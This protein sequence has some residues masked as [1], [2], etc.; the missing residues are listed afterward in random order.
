VFF[1]Y[2]RAFRAITLAMLRLVRRGEAV[3]LLDRGEAFLLQAPD[4]QHSREFQVSPRDNNLSSE[5]HHHVS[6]F[7]CEPQ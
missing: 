3:R 2:E 1:S 6:I 4:R 7:P 5:S